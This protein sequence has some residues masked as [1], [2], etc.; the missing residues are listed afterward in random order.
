MKWYYTFSNSISSEGPLW[1]FAMEFV[2]IGI[3]TGD[4]LNGLIVTGTVI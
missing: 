4:D 3:M 2:K 1:R